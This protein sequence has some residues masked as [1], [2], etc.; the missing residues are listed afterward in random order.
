MAN[1]VARLKMAFPAT[2]AD[3]KRCGLAT[4]YVKSSDMAHV[5]TALHDLGL[6]S[7]AQGAVDQALSPFEVRWV[8]SCPVK[9]ARLHVMASVFA[10]KLL[11]SVIPQPAGSGWSVVQAAVDGGS[12]VLD[13]LADISACFRGVTVEAIMEA[14][15]SH[16]SDLA[17]SALQSMS[18]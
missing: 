16:D 15:S 7:H 11:V 3:L 6:R 13:Q 9:H 8:N 18:K 12:G 17:R 1:L 10:N 14:L 4:H 5:E 2:G